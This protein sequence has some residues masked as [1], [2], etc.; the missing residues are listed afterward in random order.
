MAKFRLFRWATTFEKSY[1]I[2]VFS[3]QLSSLIPR[4]LEYVFST[5]CIGI[6]T[7]LNAPNSPHERWTYGISRIGFIVPIPSELL[8]SSR[9]LWRCDYKSWWLNY[10]KSMKNQYI[11]RLGSVVQ[12]YIEWRHMEQVKKSSMYRF[13][14]CDT[15]Y[16][17]IRT[18]SHRHTSRFSLLHNTIV[19]MN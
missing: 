16:W 1:Q 10:I 2:S 15:T 18:L 19:V 12:W 7:A 5:V 11:S 4:K 13:R 17:H 3:F 9:W 8:Q 6:K 14:M